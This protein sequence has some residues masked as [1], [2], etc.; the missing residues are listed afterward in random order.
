M[1][2]DTK[3]THRF[4]RA[5]TY[6][7]SPTD[8]NIIANRLKLPTLEYFAK[9]LFHNI[10]MKNQQICCYLLI[11]SFVQQGDLH[12]DRRNSNEIAKA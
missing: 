9:N 8:D 1:P 7:T 12:V 2:H 11:D 6:H 4:V 3:V 5:Y 10:H